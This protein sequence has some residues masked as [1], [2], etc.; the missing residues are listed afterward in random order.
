MTRTPLLI[1]VPLPPLIEL[2]SISGT[3][4]SDDHR[5]SIFP[6]IGLHPR[7]AGIQG[8]GVSAT[9]PNSC[10][11]AGPGPPL[12]R[13]SRNLPD[14]L[15]RRPRES[16][17]SGAGDEIPGFPLS[18]ERRIQESEPHFAIGLQPLFAG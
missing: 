3:T 11:R 5:I 6:G 17:D 14:R 1:A 16:G 2:Y 12:S 18:R 10:H 9:V 4:P 7:N 8:P 13:L 15:I